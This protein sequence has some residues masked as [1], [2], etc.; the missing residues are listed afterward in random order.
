VAVCSIVGLLAL[1]GGM[2]M[3]GG[4]ARSTGNEMAALVAE[5]PARPTKA[6]SPLPL[7]SFIVNGSSQAAV[8]F[9]GNT[10]T[11]VGSPGEPKRSSTIVV[12][13]VGADSTTKPTTLTAVM[14]S[15]QSPPGERNGVEDMVGKTFTI[16]C[17]IKPDELEFEIQT[18][19]PESPGHGMKLRAIRDAAGPES[20]NSHIPLLQGTWASVEPWELKLSQDVIE[21]AASWGPIHKFRVLEWTV[22]GGVARVQA[23][24]SGGNVDAQ[25]IGKRVKLLLRKDE[26]GW[27]L[28]HHSAYSAK[29]NEWPAGLISSKGSEIDLYTFGERAKR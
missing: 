4:S 10:M 8:T 15:V 28:A 21:I 20:P 22:D 27:T 11:V 12:E 18:D 26:A 29:L 24:C 23:I 25:M 1:T 9:K 17:S 3:W 13:I 14:K 19:P 7:R 5:P 2:A 16:K 6:L